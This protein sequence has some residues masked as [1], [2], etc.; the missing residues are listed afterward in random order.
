MALHTGE[1]AERDGDYS[2]PELDRVVRLTALAHGGQVLVSDTAEVLLR[3]RLSLRPLGEHVLRGLRG[4]ISVFQVVSDGLPTEFPVLR[5]AEQFAGNLPRQITSLVGRDELVRD[6]A[7]LVRE[8]RLVTLTGV[9]GVGKTRMAL[10]VGA[11]LAGE[12]PDG[13][14]VVELAAVGDPDAVPAA[15]ATVLGITP[16][17]DTPLIATVAGTL[18]G[19]RLLLDRRQLRAPSGGRRVGD[20]GDRRP[21]GPR[22]RPRHVPRA[23][24]RGC[25]GGLAC[26]SAGDRGGRRVRRRDAV[27]RPGAGRAPRLRARRP[28]HRRGGD[29]DLPRR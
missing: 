27:R 18:A 19:K 1:T 11:E 9:G 29:G 28:G 12:F 8:R 26:H 7:E 21:P 17:G 2:G 13:V 15:V 20:R 4:R 14:W 24:W 3:T 22:P 16:Q 6:V 5:S 23:A 25:R 10:E